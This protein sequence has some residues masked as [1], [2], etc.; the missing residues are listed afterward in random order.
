VIRRV[1]YTNFQRHERYV[2]DLDPLATVLVGSS[3]AGKSA[4][5]RGLFWCMLNRPGGDDFISWDAKHASVKLYTS[6]HKIER[7]RGKGVNEYR[8][9]G[10]VLRAFG[11]SNVPSEIASVLN[12]G[13][14]N[15]RLQLDAHFWFAE[16]GGEVSRRLNEVVNL[17]LIDSALEYAATEV[18]DAK[19][20]AGYATEQQQ[21]AADRLAALE[22]VPR[23]LRKAEV[24]QR[25]E[26]DHLAKSRKIVFLRSALANAQ[27]LRRRRDRLGKATLE[28]ENVVLGR[29]A[30]DAAAN[31]KSIKALLQQGRRAAR[32]AKLDLSGFDQ[33]HRMRVEADA[34]AEKV[35]DVRHL[36]EDATKL[37][38]ETCRVQ[39]SLAAA[40][41]ELRRA[42]P[43]TC[44]T[45]GQPIQKCSPS[46]RPIYTCGKRHPSAGPKKATS[47]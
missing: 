6:R 21:T 1:V 32:L 25:L 11:Q 45:C 43:P 15:F 24:V 36:I 10:R 9:D 19:A 26:T 8:I 3:D 41:L 14:D 40:E 44:P 2:L 27:R 42:S 46:S 17:S 22:W 47:G 5:V 38:E 29:R 28:A 37:K 20:A 23:F 31:V 34:F 16:S 4:L 7:V 13:E 18:R 12:V 35:R 30:L 33:L 39:K